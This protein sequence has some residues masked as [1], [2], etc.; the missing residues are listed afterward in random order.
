MTITYLEPTSTAG[1]E[2]WT[3]T[4]DDLDCD[5]VNIGVFYRDTILSH[6]WMCSDTGAIY[7]MTS[8]TFSVTLNTIP[9]ARAV[10]FTLQTVNT[11][12]S[13]I[14]IGNQFGYTSD[15]W[16]VYSGQVGNLGGDTNGMDFAQFH[17][18]IST[19]S[20]SMICYN[21]LTLEGTGNYYPTASYFHC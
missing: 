6:A 10:D 11:F 5:I 15:G 21:D 8:S 1:G 13:S 2:W 3:Y 14:A 18:F 12:S 20:S 16:L 7:A 17:G 4:Y 19:L 9:L